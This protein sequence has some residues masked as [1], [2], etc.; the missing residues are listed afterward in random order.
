M[1]MLLS[2]ALSDTKLMENS[3]GPRLFYFLIFFL[4]FFFF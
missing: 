3:E 1:L 4:L 2:C